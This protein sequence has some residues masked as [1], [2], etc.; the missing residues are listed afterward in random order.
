MLM[1]VFRRI[2]AALLIVWAVVTIVFF[3]MRIIPADPAEVVLGDQASAEALAAFR[4]QA[5]LDQPLLKQYLD[6][7]AGLAHGDLGHS[8]ITNQPIGEQ[9]AAAFPHTLALALGVLLVGVVIGIPIGVVTAVRRGT[10]LDFSGRFFSLLGLSFPSFYVGIVLLIVFSVWLGWFPVIH[11]PR[12]GTIGETLYKLVLPS[13][14]LGFVQAAYIARLTRSTM[15]ETLSQDYVR[16]AFAKGLRPWKVYFKHALRNVLIPVV[17]AIGLYTGAMLGG[18]ILTET[19]F[20]RPGLGKL[21]IGAVA[22]RDYNLIQ[23]GLIVFASIVILVNLLVDLS[24]G[25]LDPRV[26][27]G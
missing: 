11:A 5:G 19:V 2:L 17:T 20:N 15:L 8:I 27:N 13:L 3:S 24:Y 9:I 12:T 14:S 23:S 4:Q 16:T 22:Q 6:L 21:L 26:K 1:F 10:R 25:L 18:A 7:L